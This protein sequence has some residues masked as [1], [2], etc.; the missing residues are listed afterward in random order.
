[1]S[2]TT[3]TTTCAYEPC[4]KQFTTRFRPQRFCC[5]DCGLNNRR[6]RPDYS[7]CVV[8]GEAFTPKYEGHVACSPGC[9]Q[10]QRQRVFQSKYP[11]E[12][13]KSAVCSFNECGKTFT[14]RDKRHAT[15]CGQKCSALARV[16][17]RK[18][19]AAE[20]RKPRPC[21]RP[22]CRKE[23]QPSPKN[24]KQVYCSVECRAAAGREAHSAKAAARRAAKENG[25]NPAQSGE[26]P[27]PD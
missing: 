19:K 1:M 9:G 6:V 5:F 21:K 10:I 16:A 3:Y 22:E 8:C 23:F 26:N 12:P 15:F 13:P 24:A 18:A 17:E 7:E 2:R 27:L 14:P 11:P 4:G 20:K 25:S